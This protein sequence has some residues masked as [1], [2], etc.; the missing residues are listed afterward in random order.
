MKKC[1]K[2]MK[3]Y[4]KPGKFCSRTCA[5]SRTW[6]EDD[7]RQK[8]LKMQVFPNKI[9]KC[10]FCQKDFERK[11]KPSKK[12]IFCSREC[13]RKYPTNKGKQISE[14]H[15]SKISKTRKKMFEEGKLNVTGG[16]TQ[17]LS[18]KDIKVQGTYEL[19]IC[20]I[21]DSM[22][23]KNYIKRWTYTKDRVSYINTDGKKCSYLLDFKVIRND[24]SFYYIE[25]KGY[26]HENDIRKWI[27]TVNQNKNLEV[28]FETDII[29]YEMH[30]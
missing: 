7:K 24:E 11:S 18:Y 6:S 3:E 10:L 8:S 4:E 9:Y 14:I 23:E 13:S 15:K 29:R 19:R 27:A 1:P 17:W 16:T 28:W 2:C 26:I 5:N 12:N 25:C 22:V 30:M 20:R 21:L